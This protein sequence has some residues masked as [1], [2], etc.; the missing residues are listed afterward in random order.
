MAGGEDGENSGENPAPISMLESPT[1]AGFNIDQIP[2]TS[3]NFIDDDDIDIDIDDEA[4]MDP[5]II[6]DK[7][8]EVEEDEIE[9]IFSI[10]QR[11]MSLNKLP[12]LTQRHRYVLR[13]RRR[14]RHQHHRVLR[15]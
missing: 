11:K 4:A 7:L 5:E 1:S 14:R 8:D 3:K 13:R 10:D 9:R 2:R 6:R 12:S 15:K